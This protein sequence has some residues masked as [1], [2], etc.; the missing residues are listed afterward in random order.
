MPWF[1][2]FINLLVDRFQY[3]GHICS[4][5]LNR[6]MNPKLDYD[7]SVT[8][9][10]L[11]AVLDKGTSNIANLK[12]S[13]VIPFMWALFANINAT[14]HAKNLILNDDIEDEDVKAQ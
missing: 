11:N 10:L 6:S 9:E 8:V 2:S 5:A 3:N 7:C 1:L 12:D 14:S 13:N 4:N